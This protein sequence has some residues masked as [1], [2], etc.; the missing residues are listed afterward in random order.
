[1]AQDSIS[2]CRVEIESRI[3][4]VILLQ[5]AHAGGAGR[6]DTTISKRLRQRAH[7]QNILFVVSYLM[8]QALS[9]LSQQIPIE[10]V[11][12]G[13]DYFACSRSISSVFVPSHAEQIRIPFGNVGDPSQATA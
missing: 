6:I 2:K 10:H 13:Q 3:F 1:M 8:T 11:L 12:N 4:I 5:L 7:Y 9:H